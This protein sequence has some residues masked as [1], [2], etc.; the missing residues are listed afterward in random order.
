MQ[1]RV[2]KR[3]V[4]HWG[5]LGEVF[6]CMVEKKFILL[7]SQKFLHFLMKFKNYDNQY[8]LYKIITFAN[9]SMCPWIHF[10]AAL[11]N[12]EGLIKLVTLTQSK[13]SIF[14]AL[15]LFIVTNLLLNV[16]PKLLKLKYLSSVHF[17]NYHHIPN[18]IFGLRWLWKWTKDKYSN[19][20]DFGRKFKGKLGVINSKIA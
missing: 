10:V 1:P 12:Q 9:F 14:I 16:L 8:S 20:D 17:H 6:S 13:I 19:F 5:L 7:N 4:G 11:S 15:L 3:K 18:L 2:G